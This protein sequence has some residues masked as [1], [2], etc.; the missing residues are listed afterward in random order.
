MFPIHFLCWI[1]LLIISRLYHKHNSMTLQILR[2]LLTVVSC[3][4]WCLFS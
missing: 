4:T 2:P 1:I 3:I